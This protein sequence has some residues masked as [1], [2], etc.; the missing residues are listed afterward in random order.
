MPVVER[1]AAWR[2]LYE[3]PNEPAS[4][5][6]MLQ[7]WP[8]WRAKLTTDCSMRSELMTIMFCAGG[9]LDYGRLRTPSVL[10]LTN[11]HSHLR[12]PKTLFLGC[13]TRTS[14]K[15]KTL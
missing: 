10:G 8:K 13:S 5:P 14:I 9:A 6:M 12:T 4:S 7:L 1:G 11:S 2:A 15:P 3:E